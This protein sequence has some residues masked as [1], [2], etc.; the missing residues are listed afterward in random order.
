MSFSENSFF[1]DLFGDGE[2]DVK[3]G[4]W[5]QPTIEK[6][7][8]YVLFLTNLG[9]KVTVKVKV[10]VKVGKWRQPTVEKHI[11]N[12]MYFV[13]RGLGK[14]GVKA[15][16]KV[17]FIFEEWSPPNIEKRNLNFQVSYIFSVFR[18]KSR[19]QRADPT[20]PLQESIDHP[21]SVINP[22][23]FPI[24]FIHPQPHPLSR[25]IHTFSEPPA[26]TCPSLSL[27]L[28]LIS[29]S[30]S[31]RL[32]FLQTL[33]RFVEFEH[34]FWVGGGPG[35]EVFGGRERGGK[36]AQ[37]NKLNSFYASIF[38]PLF[39]KFINLSNYDPLRDEGEKERGRERIGE[40]LPSHPRRP[41]AAPLDLNL[42][43]S[44]FLRDR[45]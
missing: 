15:K 10:K 28:S 24:H 3:V 45:R 5:K 17:K 4:K 35:E 8:V 22:L 11:L 16:V 26:F 25:T 18:G 38:S 42:S 34:N 13:R 44:F 36:G 9:G 6:A 2:S 30:F 40:R 1:G 29:R 33:L 12:Y 14:A 7:Q 43:G 32:C 19:I 37:P 20:H 23:N 39:L 41:H 27:S 21:S 31:L